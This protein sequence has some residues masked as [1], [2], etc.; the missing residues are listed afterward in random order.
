M[1]RFTRLMVAAILLA[2]AVAP[3]LMLFSPRGP[4][5]PLERWMSLAVAATTCVM[6]ALWAARWPTRP[7]SLA[8]VACA[9][10]C[11][12]AACL[13]QPSPS[14]G[15]AGCTAFAALAGYVAFFHTGRALLLTIAL[16]AITA[17]VCAIHI[18]VQND[19]YGAASKLL[20]VT[21]GVLAV[22]FGGHVLVHF[23]GLEATKSDIDPLTELPN[24][25]GFH[26][27]LRALATE[28]A[29]NRATVLGVMMIDL[30]AFKRVND[31]A[32]HAAG[33]ATLIQVADILRGIRRGDSVVARI[34]GEE[35]VVGVTA[36]PNDVLGLAERLR[37]EIAENRWRV[38]ASVGVA[39]AASTRLTGAGDHPAALTEQLKGLVEAADRAMYTA[40]RA[41]G[42]RV[43]VAGTHPVRPAPSGTPRSTVAPAADGQAQPPAATPMASRTTAT[44]GNAPWS[45]AERLLL[46][47][48]TTRTSAAASMDPTPAKTKATPGAVP[49]DIVN[50]TPTNVTIAKKRL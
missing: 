39:M 24:R 4:Q 37:R 29:G 33:D 3:L 43:Q 34:G 48:E 31:T 32:G 20:V 25:R 16:A 38:T 28:S 23:L 50:P 12:A 41:G 30:D 36:P 14:S 5:Q 44:K 11:I 8:F 47:S 21:I 26:R 10:T 2:L 15:L 9:G 35:F 1:Q 40:K 7:Q 42:D 17:G 13:A 19:P 45:T 6:A 49:P 27:A 46:R 18:G 22:P